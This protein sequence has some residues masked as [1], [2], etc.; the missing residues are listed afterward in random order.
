MSKA[1]LVVDP[2]S[3]R[4]RGA[5]PAT[6]SVWLALEEVAFPSKDWNDFIVVILEAWV[7]AVLRLLEG[8]SRNEIVHF[9]DGPYLVELSRTSAAIL[10]LRAVENSYH[11]KASTDVEALPL[12]ESLLNG[13]EGVLA[14]CRGEQCWSADAEKLAESLPSLRRRVIQLRN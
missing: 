8:S 4:T 2:A 11:E 10:R 12:V 13:S 3:I 6:G 14:V 5:G 9:M 7:G 1:R